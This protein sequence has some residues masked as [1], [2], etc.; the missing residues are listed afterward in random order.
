MPRRGENIYKRKD[1]RWEGRVLGSGGKYQ[2]VYSRTYKEVKEK[3]KLLQ[4]SINR[5][6][7]AASHTSLNAATAFAAW[8]N[9]NLT[10]RVKPSTYES[11][12]RCVTKYVIPFYQ[13]EGNEQLSVQTAMDFSSR[14]NNYQGLSR[15]YKRKILTIYKTALR[16]LLKDTS[17]YNTVLNA[18]FMPRLSGTD[19]L[20][21]SVREQKLI[22]MAIVGS[23][24]MKLLGVLLCF[25]TGIRLG[26]VCGLKWADI[27]FEAG[28]MVVARTVSRVKN[29]N[30][31]GGKTTLYIGTPKSAHSNRKIPLPGFWIELVKKLKRNSFNDNFFILSD[32]ERPLDPRK[33]QNLFQTLLKQSGVKSR[34]FHAIRHTFATRA[35]ELGVDIKTLSEIL[36][37]SNV[38]ITLN[39]YAHSMFEQKKKAIEKLNTMY[40]THTEPTIFAVNNSVVNA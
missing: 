24:D 15:S 37:H 34:K 9:G 16:E 2:Y 23:N 32:T 8:L 3:K 35:L 5:P 33:Y 20:V 30:Q 29:F 21:L 11:Y 1:G 13:E 7:L 4:E 36:G 27:D 18:I 40:I 22:E 26:E 12:Y 17:E 14:I 31:T 10:I 6:T 39:I 25:Y 19:V 38:S 28:T